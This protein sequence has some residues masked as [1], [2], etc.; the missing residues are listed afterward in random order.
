MPVTGN[1]QTGFVLELGGWRADYD[2]RFDTLSHAAQFGTV[3]AQTSDLEEL[4]S[5]RESRS[6]CEAM[7]SEVIRSLKP[8][9]RRKI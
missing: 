6:R 3:V 1:A 7:L 5:V 8:K 9:A 4:E 2:D